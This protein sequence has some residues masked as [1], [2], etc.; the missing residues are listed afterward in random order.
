MARDPMWPDWVDT[1]TFYE[2]AAS[3]LINGDDLQS[4]EEK[5]KVAAFLKFISPASVRGITDNSTNYGVPECGGLPGRIVEYIIHYPNWT[6]E[7][8]RS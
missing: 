8:S 5:S 6:M 4:D 3:Y 7:E 2:W 1:S